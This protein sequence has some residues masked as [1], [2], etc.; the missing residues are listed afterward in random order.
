MAE[1]KKRERVVLATPEQVRFYI[2]RLMVQVE[3]DEIGINKARLLTQQAETV[4]K[5]ILQKESDDRL[6]MLEEELESLI[7]GESL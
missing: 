2:Q 7:E 5:A 6:A 1:K 4:L 3:N